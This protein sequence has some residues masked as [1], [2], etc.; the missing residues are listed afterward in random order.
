MRLLIAL[1]LLLIPG[2]ALAADAAR[3]AF[4]H[5][6]GEC[7]G[8]GYCSAVAVDRGAGNL[9]ADYVLRVGRRG[10]GRD[11]E[12]ALTTIGSMADGR[13][14][15]TGSVDN[16]TEMFTPP[17]DV[18]AFGE[19]NDFYFLGKGIQKLITRMVHGKAIAFGFT[20]TAGRPQRVSFPLDGLAQALIWIDTAQ[21]RLGAERVVEAPPYGLFR[22]DVPGAAWIAPAL[23]AFF[24]P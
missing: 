9:G 21:H 2:P 14:P 3:Q 15:F 23:F 16:E 10:E 18:T 7:R 20:D 6:L 8:D 22:A 12:G 4:G 1:F 17:A 11:G 13:Q 5:W 19:A 24:Q